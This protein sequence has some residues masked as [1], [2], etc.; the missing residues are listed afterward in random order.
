LRAET[1]KS[2]TGTVSVGVVGARGYVGRE[3][4]RLIARHPALGLVLASSRSRAGTPVDDVAAEA[5]AGLIFVDHDPQRIAAAAAEVLFLALPNGESGS[6]LA[7]LERAG[8]APRVIVDLSA[9]HRFDDG[10]TY[11]LPELD[12]ARLTGARRI[13]NPGCYAT[14]MRLALA[15]VRDSLAA[16]PHV[17]GVSGWSGAGSTPNDRNDVDAL[18][19]SVLPYSL[20]GHLHE[21]EASHHLDRPVRFAPSVAPFFRGIVLTLLAELDSPQTEE[22]LVGRYEDFY[23]AAPLVRCARRTPRLADVVE[24]PGAIVGGFCV[25]GEAPRR[26]GVVCVIDNLLKGAASQA[27]QNVNL[28]LG[29]P[30]ELGLAS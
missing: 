3:L 13:A 10:W 14:A 7:A 4:L 25:D 5:D 23:A 29:L 2:A 22:S 6:F 26:V 11:G 16:T 1:A 28:A 21:R 12:A 30:A 27:I 15:P 18:R 8:A 19:D 24:T 20:A 9:D 17:F